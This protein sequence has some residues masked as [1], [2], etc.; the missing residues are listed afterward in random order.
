MGDDLMGKIK[1]IGLKDIEIT[2]PEQFIEL[3]N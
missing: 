3:K 1:Y 2:S